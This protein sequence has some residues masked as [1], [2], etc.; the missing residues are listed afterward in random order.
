MISPGPAWHLASEMARSGEAPPAHAIAAASGRA[1]RA[2]PGARP[3]DVAPRLP[4]AEA[5]A[6]ADR[7]RG[8]RGIL[9]TGSGADLWAAV[10]ARRWPQVRVHAVDQTGPRWPDWTRGMASTPPGSGDVDAHPHTACDLLVLSWPAGGELR[11]RRLARRV[12]WGAHLLYVGEDR[13]TGC[14]E[15]RLFDLLENE[16][17]LLDTAPL[18]CPGDEAR[19]YRRSNPERDAGTRS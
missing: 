4:S 8:V 15:E 6:L 9:A 16:L 13:S 14:A 3:P 5:L 19:L 11:T 10:L 2:E 12:A 1:G 17:E 18:A 7:A